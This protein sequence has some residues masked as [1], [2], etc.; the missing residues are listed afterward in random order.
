MAK[1]YPIVTVV[2]SED[3]DKEQV[4]AGPVKAMAEVKGYDNEYFYDW[5]TYFYNGRHN[6]GNNPKAP[7]KPVHIGPEATIVLMPDMA[8][9]F[10]QEMLR[11]LEND[12]T[13]ASLSPYVHG[14]W[15][16]WYG[17]V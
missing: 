13:L 2:L 5:E 14:I 17:E 1:V 12:R 11:K 10:K 9:R 4:S 6:G 8:R 7:V 15:Y 3:P 16:V